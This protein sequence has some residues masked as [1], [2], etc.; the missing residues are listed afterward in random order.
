VPCLDAVLK[1]E[2]YWKNI[3]RQAAMIGI[4]IQWA[5]MDDWT[6]MFRRRQKYRKR[7]I[8]KYP[9]PTKMS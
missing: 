3:N 7:Q 5:M 4:D 2:E 1:Q 8:L 9:N 6:M